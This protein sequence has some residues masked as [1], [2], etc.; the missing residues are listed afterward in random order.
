MEI[1]Q[2]R[3]GL[4]GYG[5]IGNT[6]GIGLRQNGLESLVAYDKFAFDGPY[7]GLIQRRA[8]EAGVALVR[9]PAQLAE[10]AEIILGVTPGSSSLASAEALA[11]HLHAGHA[12]ADVASATPKIKQG[13]AERL[14][15]SEAV[16]GDASI[17]GTPRDGH[18]MPI[19]ASGQAAERIR[20]ALVPWGMQIDVVGPVIGTASGIKI[21]RSVVMKGL[22]ALLVECMLGSW[23]FGVDEYILNSIDKAFKRS[24]KDM[25]NALLTTD[26]IHAE[27]RS[28]E[29]AMSAEALADAGLDPIVTRAAAERLR[30]VASLGLKQHF[31]G[32]V[33][34]DYRTVMEIMESKGAL[35]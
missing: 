28:E 11:P 14:A 29:I 8:Q 10:Q 30:W 20:D 3:V 15:P 18:A 22:E 25:A 32:L 9:S 6:F 26:A 5:E 21:L 23:Q 24:F 35:S 2:F 13:V 16:V 17:L 34:G 4:V 19:L 12:F 33:P 31:E 1:K 27:R 7:G